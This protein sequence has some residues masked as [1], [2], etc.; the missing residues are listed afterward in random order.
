MSSNASPLVR[1]Y[2]PVERCA[3]LRHNLVILDSPGADGDERYDELIDKYCLEA[4]VF[5]SVVDAGTKLSRTV[6]SRLFYVISQF[7][8][9]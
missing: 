4:D 2:Y 1:I 7:F 9:E 8:V 5:L 3:L 6:R